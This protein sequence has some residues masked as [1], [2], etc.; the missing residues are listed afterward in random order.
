MHWTDPA[1][2]L[3]VTAE[4]FTHS[5]FPAVE[6]VLRFENKGAQD[7]PL[8]E[9]VQ[10]M[11]IAQ[12]TG[13]ARQALLLHEL[14]G[15][16]CGATSFLPKTT[17]VEVGAEIDRAP[18]GG[19]SSSI[20]AFPFFTTEYNSRGLIVAIGWTGQWASHFE[21]VEN[22]PVRMRAGMELTRLVLHPGERIRTPRMLVMAWEG[23]RANAQNQFR[24]IMLLRSP[25]E[26]GRPVALPVA[27]QTFDRY[28]ARPD[29]TCEAG[30]VKAV[31]AAHEL[32]C[33]TY[34]FDAAWFPKHFPN[35]VGSWFAEPKEFP[36]GLK[37]IADR[38]HQY[39]MKFIVW[40]EPERVA[41]DTQISNEHPEFVFGGKEGGL[42]ML[43][44]PKARRHLTDML[45]ERIGEY[46]IDVYRND[47]NM[48]PLPYWRGNDAPDRQGIT[49]IRYIEGLYA[50]WDEL[51]AQHPGLWIDNC[52]SGGRRIDIEMCSRSV[53]LWRSDTNCFRGNFEWKQAQSMSLTRY[54]PLQTACV[55]STEAYDARSASTGGL[56]CQFD[57][58]ADGF[59]MDRAK[60]LVAEA[61]DRQ[62]YWYGDFYPLTPV[63]SANDQ[64]AAWQFHRAD[65]DEGIAVAFRREQCPQAGI[66]GGLS[67]VDPAGR[68]T[69]DMTDE[70]GVTVTSEAAGAELQNNLVLRIPEKGQSLAV[71]YR[72]IR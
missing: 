19:R 5:R 22:G 61:K 48:D 71:K 27:L 45:S 23:D 47:F 55:W 53:P 16:A 31:D 3:V 44:D 50:M 56:L 54:V 63:S 41:K 72:R 51:L 35:G 7:T 25:Q 40:F 36:R 29:W 70:K 64:F 59:A 20:S 8:I 9:D 6:W 66:I 12:R 57:Y 38:C 69:V 67:G 43:N 17:R 30:Q 34:W 68:Y 26:Q 15:D 13:D 1:T 2:G 4:V 32:G 10:A 39:G 49:E 18:T 33:D 14:E 58:L 21:R 62:K 60:A 37:P 46:G 52:S 11:D 24:R 42:F 28:N 65:L